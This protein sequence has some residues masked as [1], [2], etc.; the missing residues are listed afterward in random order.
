MYVFRLVFRIQ[1]RRCHKTMGMAGTL[2]EI[3]NYVHS[4]QNQ[5]EFLSM[6][7]AAACSSPMTQTL[8]PKLIE[9]PREPIH[10][11]QWRWRDGQEK[12]ME[13]I[14]VATTQH[15]PFDSTFLAPLFSIATQHMY[16][17]HIYAS[18]SGISEMC[19]QIILPM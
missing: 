8:K 4:L 11:S 3:I 15:G 10:M 6:E 5:V 2:E 17:L 9:R 12:D 14:T 1:H 16:M 19:F 13:I 18:L 7:L